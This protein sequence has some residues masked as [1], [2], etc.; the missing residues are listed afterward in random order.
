[1]N[2]NAEMGT[3]DSKKWPLWG[4]TAH[5]KVCSPIRSGMASISSFFLLQKKNK[6]QP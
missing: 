3:S 2:K 6:N 5:E 4:I 1:M